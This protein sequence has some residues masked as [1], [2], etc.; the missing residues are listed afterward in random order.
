MKL[1]PTSRRDRQFLFIGIACLLFSVLMSSFLIKTSFGVFLLVINI[2]SS[3]INIVGVYF[4]P[5]MT[6]STE[7]VEYAQMV[8][9]L[10]GTREVLK[11]L[12]TFLE[13]ER[14]RINQAEQTVS[15]LEGERAALEPVVK[16]QRETVEAILRAHTSTVRAYA[17]KDRLMGFGIGV[18]S[19]MVAGTILYA[20]GVG[21]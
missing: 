6:E 4:S 17:W 18:L 20:L 12:S 11:N 16:T 9:H 15:R 3:V 2:L 1:I 5:D 7:G 19:S 14:L 8:A 13:R 10:D 21:R